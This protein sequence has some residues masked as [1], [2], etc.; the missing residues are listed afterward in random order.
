VNR[1][2]NA[3]RITLA[4][5]LFSFAGVALAQS[6][7]SLDALGGGLWFAVCEFTNSPI[8][9]AVA[10]VALV[11]VVILFMLDEARGFVSTLLKIGI[12]VAIILNIVTVLQLIGLENVIN[13]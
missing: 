7:N 13:C 8:V 12:G 1:I 10:A 4:P 2:S 3:A 5:F 11:T 9:A 6:G